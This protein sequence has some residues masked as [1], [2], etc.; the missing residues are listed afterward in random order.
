VKIVIA[1]QAKLINQ[2]KKI[3]FGG[4]RSRCYGHTAALRLIVQPCDED[5]YFFTFFR[6]MEHRWNELD[7]GKPKY[8]GKKSV[9]VPLCLPQIP[10][11]LTRDRT[12][13]S[14]VRGRR[15]TA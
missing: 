8:S 3:F 5:D 10:H 12:R 2:Y 11:G 7:R 6:V 13:A 14:T 1:N 9:S 4:P 15:L